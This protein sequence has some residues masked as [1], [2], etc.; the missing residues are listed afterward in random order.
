MDEHRT[1]VEQSTATLPVRIRGVLVRCAICERDQTLVP[2]HA[3]ADRVLT[4]HL[5]ECPGP[6]SEVAGS[7]ER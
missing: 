3:A 6:P 4:T 1:A 2:S 5:R 7:S